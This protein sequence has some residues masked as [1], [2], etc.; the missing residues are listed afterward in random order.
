MRLKAK[1]L[2]FSLSMAAVLSPLQISAQSISN[3]PIVIREVQD[4][5]FAYY[6][7]EGLPNGLDFASLPERLPIH[8]GL[9]RDEKLGEN[10]LRENEVTRE[11]IIHRQQERV[12]DLFFYAKDATRCIIG[13]EN[14]KMVTLTIIGEI[15][16]SDTIHL[17]HM[18]SA[19]MG[20]KYP[21]YSC[22][23]KL[24]LAQS[25]ELNPASITP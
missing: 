21:K 3:A 14:R 12:K 24:N 4:W 20:D 7:V 10:F 9:R 16:K 25:L 5:R 2:S 11:Q 15:N 8:S 13:N 6:S 22:I 19:A 1:I 18:E 17:V 23:K